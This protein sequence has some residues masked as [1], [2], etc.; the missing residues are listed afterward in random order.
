MGFSEKTYSEVIVTLLLDN[1]V[2]SAPIGV[3]LLD[4]MLF[5]RVFKGSRTYELLRKGAKEGTICVTHDPRLFYYSIIRKE[6]L[7]YIFIKGINTPCL[8]GCNGYVYFKVVKYNDL[9][10]YLAVY[11]KPLSVYLR[12]SIPKTYNRASYAIIEALV[13]YSKIPYTTPKKICK[14]VEAIKHCVDIVYHSS[15]SRTYRAIA[16]DI[17]KRA[18]SLVETR[19]AST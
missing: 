13:Y 14:Y 3:L 9:G 10:D 17:L 5:S 8:S 1:F 2:N 16:R 4:D 6:K 19:K 18:L 7:K 11:M 15:R 12:K